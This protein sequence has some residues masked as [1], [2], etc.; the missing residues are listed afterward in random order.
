MPSLS[1]GARLY[2][3]CVVVAAADRHK[4]S[5]AAD[6]DHALCSCQAPA[7]ADDRRHAR[8]EGLLEEETP[9]PGALSVKGR[10]KVKSR[11]SPLCG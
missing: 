1:L 6:P 10:L 5:C 8:A 7:P 2:I 4:P 9:R 11:V 3:A